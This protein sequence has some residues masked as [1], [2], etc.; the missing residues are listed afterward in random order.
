MLSSETNL[1]DGQRSAGL[2][3]PRVAKPSIWIEAF[4]LYE[5]SPARL[6]RISYL[7]LSIDRLL[8]QL[9]K[10]GMQGGEHCL[11][12]EVDVLQPFVKKSVELL[13]A[14]AIFFCLGVE[15]KA[16]ARLTA[17]PPDSALRTAVNRSRDCSLQF[18]H[19]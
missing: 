2:N 13:V 15:M 5:L 12:G 18:W 10:Q 14:F 4:Y 7:S 16:S 11:L 3:P 6:N 9:R 19:A 8:R 17:V 1:F